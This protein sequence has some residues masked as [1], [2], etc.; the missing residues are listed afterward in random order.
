VRDGVEA[1]GEGARI[2]VR[3][4]RALTAGGAAVLV[5]L[6]VLGFAAVV[7]V[8]LLLRRFVRVGGFGTRGLPPASAAYRRLQRALRRRG[9]GLT[10]ASAPSE[11]LACADR[12]GA[13]RV[14]REIVGAYVA[15]SFGGRPTSATDAERLDGLL[16]ELRAVR[17]PR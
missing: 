9:A 16:R 12:L 1:V 5:G 3:A 2:L 6:I 10:P 15:E 11:T 13:G 7:T 17:V 14:S 4:L 8:G